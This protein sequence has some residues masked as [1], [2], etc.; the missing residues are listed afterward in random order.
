VAR[1]A[2]GPIRVGMRPMRESEQTE[3]VR[4]EVPWPQKA[5]APVM[6]LQLRRP[7][8]KQLAALLSVVKGRIEAGA[9][10]AR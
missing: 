5:L 2:F 8:R 10:E 7:L 4:V 1:I 6:E 9:A 3:R